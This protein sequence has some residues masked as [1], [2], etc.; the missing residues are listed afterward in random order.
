VSLPWRDG[1]LWPSVAGLIG[2]IATFA[3][4]LL[5]AGKARRKRL[6]RGAAL[7]KDKQRPIAPA[8]WW[9]LPGLSLGN[10]DWSGGIASKLVFIGAASAAAVAATDLLNTIFTTSGQ[11]VVFAALGIVGA[12]V[13]GVGPLAVALFPSLYQQTVVLDAADTN[14]AA[15]D[16]RPVAIGEETQIATVWGITLGAA[17][18][19]AGVVIQL[20]ALAWLC[21]TANVLQWMI[22]PLVLMAIVTVAYSWVTTWTLT[23]TGSLPPIVDRLTPTPA[24]IP[25][26]PTTLFPRTARLQIRVGDVGEE[27]H[28]IALPVAVTPRPSPTAVPPRP[29]RLLP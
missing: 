28:E 21:D 14:N 9:K 7:P 15:P 1:F 3:G 19:A 10:L 20:G 27:E 26:T 11:R 13:V 18:T 4:G 8:E 24:A 6:T 22:A 12:L 17:F 5:V 25:A 2:W 23:A 29:H 16:N